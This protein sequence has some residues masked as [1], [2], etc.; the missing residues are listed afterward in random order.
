MDISNFVSLKQIVNVL[1]LSGKYSSNDRFITKCPFHSP[2]N[3]PSFNIFKHNNQYYY[4]CFSCNNDSKG[5]I[6][7]LFK[8]L[9]NKSIYKSFNLQNDFES[10]LYKKDFNI[11]YQEQTINKKINLVKGEILDPFYNQKLIDY[12]HNRNITDEFIDYF[13]F[14][15]TKYAEFEVEGVI[16]K[17]Y[18][19]FVIP[20][21]DENNN[22]VNYECRLY[23]Y[24][25]LSEYEV[26]EFG[27]K[28]KK[29]KKVL[30]IKNSNFKSVIFNENNLD[31]NKPVFI[32]EGILDLNNL[33]SLG[34]RNISA[35]F[36]N[37]PSEQRLKK[38]N[39][40]IEINNFMDNDEGGETLFSILDKGLEKEF[41]ILIPEKIGDDPGKLN[42][43][44]TELCIKNKVTATERMLKKY[45]LNYKKENIMW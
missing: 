11:N 22:L 17:I 33:F 34:Y 4:K 26:D 31:Y 3:N 6:N 7:T 23:D 44:Q 24:D 40:F 8:K 45:D 30:Y 35:L 20:I 42:L 39:K 32:T 2:D 28:I 36:N 9:L 25:K 14:G 19:R 1:G 43:A 18:D 12:L 41:Y 5:H 37:Q 16:T 15:Y 27:K 13:N 38:L 10:Y 21:Y 29:N